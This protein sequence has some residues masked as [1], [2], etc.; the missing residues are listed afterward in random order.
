MAPI[1]VE[2]EYLSYLSIIMFFMIFHI[3]MQI[4]LYQLFLHNFII[5][6]IFAFF[7][8]F[9]PLY[10]KYHPLLISFY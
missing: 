5:I 6:S 9:N 7:I 1:E 8:K 3:L 10:S 2:I 4:L